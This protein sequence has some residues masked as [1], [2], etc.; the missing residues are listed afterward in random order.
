MILIGNMRVWTRRWIEGKILFE[1]VLDTLSSRCCVPL[2]ISLDDEGAIACFLRGASNKPEVQ[3][4][5]RYLRG[6]LHEM[7]TGTPNA[8]CPRQRA[9]EEFRNGAGEIG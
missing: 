7:P 4:G 8:P 9:T 3:L 1:V 2:G 6:F 5:S